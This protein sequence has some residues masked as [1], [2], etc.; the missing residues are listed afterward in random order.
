MIPFS[1][2]EE[3]SIL[4]TP[5]Q[6]QVFTHLYTTKPSLIPWQIQSCGWAT[7]QYFS[8]RKPQSTLC[9][10][11]HSSPWTGLH[12]VKS[13]P[14]YSSGNTKIELNVL[15]LFK[16]F[17]LGKNYFYKMGIFL[18]FSNDICDIFVYLKRRKKLEKCMY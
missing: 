7:T 14:S 12:W 17:W 10:Q 16:Q 11:R 2:P 18:C 6:I 4:E 9:N 1:F 5:F 13:S 8:R 15:S 3:S